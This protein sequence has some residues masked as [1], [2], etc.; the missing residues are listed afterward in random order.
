MAKYTLE[1][2][3]DVMMEVSDNCIGLSKLCTI[4]LHLEANQTTTCKQLNE[5]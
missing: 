2:T 3:V 4:T 1:E 5:E